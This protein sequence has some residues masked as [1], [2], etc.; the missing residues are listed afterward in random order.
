MHEVFQEQHGNRGCV[1]GLVGEL[2]HIQIRG[3]H[4]GLMIEHVEC[5]QRV[6]CVGGRGDRQVRGQQRGLLR[7]KVWDKLDMRLGA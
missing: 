6:E 1:Q 3:Q 4:V 2:T 7:G 5:A